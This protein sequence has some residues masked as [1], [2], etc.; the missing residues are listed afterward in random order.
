MFNNIS[1]HALSGKILNSTCL[2]I[3]VMKV[4]QGAFLTFTTL[5]MQMKTEIEI[6]F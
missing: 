3:L 1:M 4:A 5:N 6:I 2:Q